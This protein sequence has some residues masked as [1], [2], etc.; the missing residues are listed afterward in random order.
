MDVM[1]N[2]TAMPEP[3]LIWNPDFLTESRDTGRR[4]LRNDRDGA[5]VSLS[6]GEYELL[7]HY[8]CCN[9][10]EY[11]CRQMT[12]Y[13][14]NPGL[15]RTVVDKGRELRL[16][17]PDGA[18]DTAPAFRRPGSGQALLSYLGNRLLHFLHRVSGL[19]L[20][21]EFSG[22]LRFYKLFSVNLENTWL[23]RLSRRP[24]FGQRAFM[25]YL[26]TLTA[27]LAVPAVYPGARF[28]FSG[29]GMSHVPVFGL[30]AA[31]VAAI[32]GCLFLHET[33][34]YMVY[35]HFGGQSNRMGVGTMFFVFPVLY[36]QTEQVVWWPRRQKLMVSA[37]GVAMD[38]LM[39]AALNAFLHLYHH[40][41]FLALLA[42]CLF[43]YY[44]VQLAANFNFLCPGTD[45]YYLLE[46]LLGVERLLGRSYEAAR[47]WWKGLFAGRKSSVNPGLVIYFG[48]ACLC[49]SLY[50]LCLTVVLSYPLW[51]GLLSF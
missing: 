50:W 4:L 12:L 22:N 7:Q 44:L 11:V 35:R 42:A 47:R 24:R 25:A 36:T 6:E 33:G 37:A 39:L 9:S 28:A 41:D 27:L 32:F 21:A 17:V 1:Q 18:A 13:E 8:A 49:I 10:C 19:S 26:L 2:G 45:G 31:M 23:H 51:A 48:L 46:D 14:L 16:L 5:L 15:C 40:P 29:F 34:H 43:W 3:G 30:F 20:S 38:F